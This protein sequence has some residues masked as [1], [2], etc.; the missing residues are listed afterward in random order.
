[1]ICIAEKIFVSGY[2]VVTNDQIRLD[3]NCE[4]LYLRLLEEHI[5]YDFSF[6]ECDGKIQN[7]IICNLL[8]ILGIYLVTNDEEI[9]EIAMSIRHTILNTSSVIERL[10]FYQCPAEYILYYS[11]RQNVEKV[12]DLLHQ[13]LL[14]LGDTQLPRIVK[15]Y[16]DI[17]RSQQKTV[18][19]THSTPCISHIRIRKIR[20]SA[21]I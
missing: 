12:R 9:C 21:S 19:P 1:M 18:S 2:I 11:E 7:I 15:I 17:I 13:E 8:R 14:I 16:R 6:R 10:A 5:N 20:R 4:E 3:D